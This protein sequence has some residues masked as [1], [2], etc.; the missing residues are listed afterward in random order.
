MNGLLKSALVIAIA[1]AVSRALGLVREVVIADVFGAGADYDAFVIAFIIPH[2]LRKLLAEGALSTAFIPL[3]SAHLARGRELA[4]RFASNVLT[5]ALVVFP[6]I[7]AL[8]IWLAPHYVP[9]LA[10]GFD[11]AKRALA[12]ELTRVTFPFIM[13]VGIAALFMGVLNS[14]ERFFV[15]AFAP[16]FFNLGLIAGALFIA[17]RVQPPVMGLAWGV[18]LGGL[19][20]L[21]FQVPFLRGRLRY[22]F[23]FDPLDEDLKRLMA[24]MLPTVLGLIVVEL[25]VLVDNKL[26]SRLEDGAIASL[27]YA[28][29]LFQLPLGVFAIAAATALLPRLSF[30]AAQESTGDFVRSFRGG[31]RLALFILLPATVGL[32]VLGGPIIALLFEHG[33]FTPQDTART[34]FALRFLAIGMVGY[35]VMVLVVRAFYALQDT[36]TPVVV[37]AF[38]VGLNIGLNLLLIGPLRIGGVALATSLAGLVEMG[39]LI[40][41]LG[42]RLGTPLLRPLA[43]QVGR[44]GLNAALMGAAVYLVDVE[45]TRLDVG[46]FARVGLGLAVGTLSYGALALRERRVR[47]VFRASGLFTRLKRRPAL[48]RWLGSHKGDAP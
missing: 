48:V 35:G 38:A 10:D 21:L 14:H 46:E 36:R 39:L 13:L 8:G 33:R 40:V 2:L 15:P 9:F 24:L 47:E 1:T 42:R 30:L 18:L 16:V 19:G 45:L 26:A 43:P 25:N 23:T 37:S 29:R 28:V 34:L 7:V 27:Q 41:I 22:R 12:V 3:F 6:V 44:M 5:V 11:A 31:L 17:P 4:V 32:V 20:Q